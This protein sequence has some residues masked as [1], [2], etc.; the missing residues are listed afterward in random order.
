[1][2]GIVRGVAGVKYLLLTCAEV[3][4]GQL[5]LCKAAVQF[6]L[7][8]KQ[9][10]D[11]RILA[12]QANGVEGGGNS[13]L[14]LEDSGL[15]IHHIVVTAEN[16]PTVGSGVQSLQTGVVGSV[17]RNVGSWPAYMIK[18]AQIDPWGKVKA[19]LLPRAAIQSPFRTALRGIFSAKVLPLSL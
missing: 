5:V 9:P 16:T 14:Q 17:L 3:G 18:L 1:M 6:S 8:T 2:V 10:D 15:T 11:S 7:G 13:S 19:L 12:G 4:K